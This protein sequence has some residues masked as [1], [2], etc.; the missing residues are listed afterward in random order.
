MLGPDGI[1][2]HYQQNEGCVGVPDDITEE[3]TCST[4]SNEGNCKLKVQFGQQQTLIRPCGVIIAC[5][6]FFGVEAVSNILEFVK[7]VFLVPNAPKP[8]HF[9]YNTAHDHKMTHDYFQKN[10]NPVDYPELMNNNGTGWWFNTSIAE[11]INVWLG[12]YHA[13]CREMLLVKFNFF[14]GEMILKN[15][16]T[17]TNI[18]AKGLQPG[19]APALSLS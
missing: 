8:E 12:S 19:H 11:Q 7:K 1:K 9:I 4:K 3:E 14:L 6:M 16:T 18:K 10:C 13:I 17:I 15:V 2:H 5:A